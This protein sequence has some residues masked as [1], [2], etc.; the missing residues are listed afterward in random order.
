M[1]I[2]ILLCLQNFRE[3]TGNILTPFVDWL[4]YSAITWLLFVPF[5]VYW[6]VNK[7][8]GLF[9]IISLC[10]SR[11][12][13]GIIKVTACVYRPF[14]RDPRIIPAGHKPTGYSF[15]SGHTMWASPILGGLAV[16]GR[17]SKLF[18]SFCAVMIVLVAFSRNY[19]GVHTPQDVIVGTLAGLLSVWIAS[20]IM[21]RPERENSFLMAGLILCVLG[22]IYTVYKPYPMDYV[23]GKL[24]VDPDRM[25]LDT[26]YAVGMMTGFITGRWIE[27][28]YIKFQVTGLNVRGIILAA[29]GL[30]PV[31]Y[32]AG[33]F[34]G[35]YKWLYEVLEPIFTV[36]GGR[37]VMGFT[38]MF[39]TVAVWPFVI[40]LF[41]GN[42]R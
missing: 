9:M 24:L 15:P 28:R 30:V 36:R 18:V 7:K 27:R 34:A 22:V 12:L 6:C 4:S 5:V 16:I 23:D 29:I 2:E 35:S 3:A 25:M 11:F 1:D 39:W 14:I 37:F 10:I 17:R 21:S 13:N 8:D 31:Y 33:T 40:K 26:F 41:C 32:I 38:L 20:L 42:D 19:L